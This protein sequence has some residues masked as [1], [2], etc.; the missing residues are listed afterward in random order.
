MQMNDRNNR[1]DVSLEGEEDSEGKP[2]KDGSPD[3]VGHER[4]LTGSCFDPGKRT[5][6]ILEKL[7]AQTGGF[8]LIPD[9]RFEGIDFCFGAD[10]EAGHLTPSAETGLQSLD[11]PFPCLGLARGSPMCS[12]SLLQDAL[13]PLMKRHLIQ[14][15]CN[16]VPE[17]LYVV[18]LI[19][20]RK[21]VES[22]RWQ[23][24]WV[25]HHRDYTAPVGVGGRF[26]LALKW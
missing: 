10:L 2:A 18:D 17:R 22:R 11:D 16:V 13:L 12:E 23:W 8:T 24:Y 21:I 19:L 15:G 26:G 3:G 5:A 14:A 4:E 1:S 25:P 6:E 20:D 9:G 7:I